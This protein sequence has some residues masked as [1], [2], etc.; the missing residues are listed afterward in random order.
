VNDTHDLPEHVRRNRAH[1][2]TLAAGYAASGERAWARNEPAWGIWQTPESTLRMLPENLAGKDAIEL[3]CG[4]G[5][6]SAWLARRGARPVGIDNSEAQL[7][8][9]RRLQL[10]H[11]IEFPLI[12][13]NAEHVPYPDAS[14]DLAISEYGASI[15]AD[16]NAWVPEAARLL[17][18]GGRLIFLINATLLMLCMP[19]EERPATNELVRPLRGLHRLEWSDDQSVNFAL[20]YGD[21]IRLLRSSGFTI[22]NLVEVWPAEGATTTFPYVTLDWARKWPTEEI[23]IARREG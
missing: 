5:Y 4:T 8:T 12:H 10:E 13:G 14:F 9:A 6:I 3:G 1:W 11:G 23:W 18:P 17:R 21:W 22:E 20:G 15:W 19:D 2:D 16:P 7:A